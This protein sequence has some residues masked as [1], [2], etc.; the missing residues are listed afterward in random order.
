[1][2]EE[3]KSSQGEGCVRIKGEEGS[4]PGEGCARG[5]VRVKDVQV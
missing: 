1:M 5:A 2:C 4:S 3:E